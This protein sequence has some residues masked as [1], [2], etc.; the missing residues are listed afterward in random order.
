[1]RVP[2]RRFLFLALAAGALTTAAVGLNFTRRTEPPRLSVESVAARLAVPWSIAFL[3]S[4]EAVFTERAGHVRYVDLD[5]GRVEDVGE[6]EVRAVGEGGL[7]GVDVVRRRST[8]LYLYH[9]YVSGGRVVNKVVKASYNGGLDDVVDVLTGIPGGNIHNGGRLKT[10][11]DG[12]LYI[13]TG[14]GGMP[15][16]SQDLNSLGGKILRINHDGTVPADNPF[17]T[18]VYAYGLRNPQGLAWR[19][20]SN[21][22]YC[23]D[24]GPSG[25]R[26]R[27]AHDEVNLVLP[28]ENYGW[29]NIIG[30]EEG[31]GFRKPLIHSGLETWAPSGCCFYTS[32]EIAEWYGSLFFAC[33]RGQHLHRLTLDED[34]EEVT[35]SE[36]LYEGVFGRLRDVVEGPDGSLYILTSNRDGR[37][38]PSAEDDRI[39]RISSRF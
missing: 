32:Y 10:G 19:K 18:P 7:L 30:D 15:E 31:P 14:E 38:T 13:T 20:P 8:S 24:H 27:F 21:T 22:L 34:G 29:P 9:T 25:E 1:L 3:N 35:A 28:G 26:L 17:K 33:L 5:T 23:T 11:P 16:L 37:G 2:R 6:L 12:M 36:K 39:L 4:S